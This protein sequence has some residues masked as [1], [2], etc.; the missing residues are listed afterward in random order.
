[1]NPIPSTVAD[2]G[3]NWGAAVSLPPEAREV[4]ASHPGGAVVL[5]PT[6]SAGGPS[7]G[8]LEQARGVG[9][10]VVLTPS[11]RPVHRIYCIV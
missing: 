8:V 1:M 4:F 10:E 2:F 6:Y 3:R 11:C 9:I 7:A 5:V